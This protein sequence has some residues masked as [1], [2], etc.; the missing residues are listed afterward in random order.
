MKKDSRQKLKGYR[1]LSVLIILLG[2]LFMIYMITVED[3][4]G[5]LPLFLIISGTVGFIINKSH[6]K[7]RLRACKAIKCTELA[8]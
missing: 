2:V 4:P 1:M 3:E 6:L 5:A 7:K 8:K